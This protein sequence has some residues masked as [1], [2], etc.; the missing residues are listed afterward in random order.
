MKIMKGCAKLKVTFLTQQA[1]GG[2]MIVNKEGLA[3][4]ETLGKD[5]LRYGWNT[6]I[7]FYEIISN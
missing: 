6:S 1:Y 7:S 2:R 5:L 4:G 3:G